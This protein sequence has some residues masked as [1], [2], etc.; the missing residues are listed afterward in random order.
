MRFETAL[1]GDGVRAASVVTEI[2]QIAPAA[3]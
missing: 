3:K 1:P 2:V